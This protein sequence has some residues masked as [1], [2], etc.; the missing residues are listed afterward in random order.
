MSI[1]I[2]ALSHRV[3]SQ[4]FTGADM[5]Y[6]LMGL[7][8]YRVEP[9]PSDDI[10]Q[11][12]ARISLANDNDRLI[13]RMVA[14]FPAPTDNIRKLFEVLGDVDQYNNH[15]WDLEPRCELVWAWVTN[16]TM[17]SLMNVAP[18]PSAGNASPAYLTNAIRE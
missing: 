14:M 3:S 16:P 11:V 13:E 17:S 1:A 6:A 2:T 5:A 8:H 15:L 4:D 18:C 9:D 7:L 10:F 12:V